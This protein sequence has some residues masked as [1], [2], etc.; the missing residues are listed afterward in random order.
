MVDFAITKEKIFSFLEARLRTCTVVVVGSNF[1]VRDFLFCHYVTKNFPEG[2]GGTLLFSLRYWEAPPNEYEVILT[3]W[4]T[5]WGI[6]LG[7]VTLNG[8]KTVFRLIISGSFNKYYQI[9]NIGE[10]KNGVNHV[11][12][13]YP[14]KRVLLLSKISSQGKGHR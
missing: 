12:E 3:S 4:C 13:E 11:I 8:N 10:G 6:Y 9:R 1:F 2:G 5:A 14:I 7:M